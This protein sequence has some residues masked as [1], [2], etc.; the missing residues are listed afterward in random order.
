MNDDF[1]GID[2]NLNAPQP[3]SANVAPVAKSVTDNS[4]TPVTPVMFEF[5][6][7]I[8]V[9]EIFSKLFSFK[10][11]AVFAIAL[12]TLFFQIINHYF[13]DPLSKVSGGYSYYDYGA[14][15]GRYVIRIMHSAMAAILVALP[16]YLIV[17]W[18]WMRNFIANPNKPE[19]R[20]TRWVTH[21]VIIVAA[22]VLVGD[23]IGLIYNLLEGEFASR[24]I[25]KVLS[26]AVI[27]ASIIVFYTFERLKIEYRKEVASLVF[28]APIAGLV[29]LGILGIILGFAAGGAPGTERARKFDADRAND[30]R[31]LSSGIESFGRENKRLPRDLDEL[32]NDSR[33]SYYADGVKD[34]ETDESYEYK[35]V[36]DNLLY[37][38]QG[39]YELCAD[40]ALS[41]KELDKGYPYDYSSSYYDDVW[42]EYDEGRSCKQKEVTTYN[43][44]SSLPIYD[45]TNPPIIMD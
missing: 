28:W 36:S 33:Y 22:A 6:P 11:L 7:P 42:S 38:G 32:K 8:P 5:R 43:S 15:Y 19:S 37:G 44:G 35:I 20:L 29:I 1:L 24:V 4:D 25:L 17:L 39:T 18:Y 23:I 14:Y 30:L 27:A 16:A 3:K 10:L 9:V 41:S 34:P 40:F 13:P 12:G 21:F 26:I 31:Q 45:Y 2:P